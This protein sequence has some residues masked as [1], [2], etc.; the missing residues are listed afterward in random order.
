[1]SVVGSQQAVLAGADEFEKLLK[2]FPGQATRAMAS[3][4][5][6]VANNVMTVSKE[7]APLDLGPLQNSGIVLDPE[8][9]GTRVSVTLGFGGPAAP[10]AEEQH[11]RLDFHHSEPGRKAKYLEDPMNAAAATFEKD[12]AA[13]MRD[14]FSRSLPK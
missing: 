5:F 9:E 4:M 14:Q 1:V 3:G 10:Y 7:E 13:V 2:A 12:V 6:L 8:I 11:E